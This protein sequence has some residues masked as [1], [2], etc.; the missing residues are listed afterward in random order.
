MSDAN[1]KRLLKQDFAGTERTAERAFSKEAWDKMPEEMKLLA[2]EIEFNVRGGLT[3]RGKYNG[4]PTFM[5]H[6]ENEDYLLALDE[7]DRG[8]TPKGG[9]EKKDLGSRTDDLK[10]WYRERTENKGA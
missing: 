9:G 2:R 10:A 7:I 5:R 6:I 8:Y 1:A 4:F 3:G